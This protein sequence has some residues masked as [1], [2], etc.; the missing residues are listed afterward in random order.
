MCEQQRKKKALLDGCLYVSALIEDKAL[1][2]GSMSNLLLAESFSA[3]DFEKLLD[4]VKQFDDKIPAKMTATSKALERGLK[5]AEKVFDDYSS[6]KIPGRKF[7]EMTSQLAGLIESI[8][9]SLI[10]VKDLS[11]ALNSMDDITPSVDKDNTVGSVLSTQEKQSAKENIQKRFL[12]TGYLAR[13]FGKKSE[14]YGLTAE[15]LYRDIVDLTIDEL[16]GLTTRV[17]PAVDI[18]V[19]VEDAASDRVEPKDLGVKSSELSAFI[20]RHKGVE[21]T[22]LVQKLKKFLSDRGVKF[23]TSERLRR[24]EDTLILERWRRMAGISQE[25]DDE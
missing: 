6:G 15:E 5:D 13:L 23:V 2:E 12:P 14:W 7:A 22:V 18:E 4:R 1:S 19:D 25:S 16:K 17:P 9:E 11:V 3:D 20:E 24:T 10:S 21:P 8:A